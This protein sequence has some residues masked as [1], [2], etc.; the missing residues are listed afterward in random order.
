MN[1]FFVSLLLLGALSSSGNLPYWATAG[2]YGLMPETS[3]SLACVQA[4]MPF[5]ESKTF[6]WRWGASLSANLYDDASAPS[7]SPLHP[8]VD[9]LYASARWKALTLDVGSK[10]RTLEFL[11]ANP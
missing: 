10:R 2:Q 8:M 9:E 3:G 4:G 6:Q 7:S 1:D 5:D 11:A